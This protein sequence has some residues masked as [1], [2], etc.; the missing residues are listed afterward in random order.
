M[1]VQPIER[2]ASAVYVARQPI[3]ESRVDVVGYELLFRSSV[4]NSYDGANHDTSTMEVLSDCLIDFGLDALVGTKR[5]FINFTESLLKSD[6]ATMLPPDRVVVEMLESVRPEPVIVDACLRLKRL[7]YTLALDDFVETEGYKPLM[8]LAD[9]IKVDFTISDAEERARIARCPWASHVR[10]LAEKV[11]TVAE[12]TEA[13]DLGYSLFQGYFFSRPHVLSGR[14]VSTSEILCLDAFQEIQKP[15]MDYDRV[16]DIIKR[17]VSFTYSL[18][19]YINSASIGMRMRV[20]SIRHALL[21]LGQKETA[22]WLS[23]VALRQL[24]GGPEEVLGMCIVRGRM[25]ELLAEPAGLKDR[26]TDL[27]LLGVFSTID[28]LL[29]RPTSEVLNELPLAPDVQAALLGE[30]SPLTRVFQLVLAYERGDWDDVA[31]M[32][33]EIG[34]DETV[35]PQLYIQAVAWASEFAPS[36]KA[37]GQVD[38]PPIRTGIVSRSISANAA[39]SARA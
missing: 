5:A 16:A 36:P 3:F 6:V 35:I 39:T 17:D 2:N 31:S 37:N 7:G 33:R 25:A 30:E 11:E 19:R 20:N 38:P 9:I 32:A 26:T 14:T 8:D 10:L 34:V 4:S 28:A 27:F 23:L 22:R 18:L 29:G 1:A 13:K 21:L 12:F 15:E 24:A